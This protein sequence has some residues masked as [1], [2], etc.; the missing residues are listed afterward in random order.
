MTTPLDLLFRTHYLPNGVGNLCRCS[1]RP[2]LPLSKQTTGLDTS[3]NTTQISN[4]MRYSQIV[5]S[6]GTVESSSS[7]PTRKPNG[8]GGPTFSY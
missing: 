2:P 6:Y 5:K 7:T 4:S 1:K 8:L 3:T